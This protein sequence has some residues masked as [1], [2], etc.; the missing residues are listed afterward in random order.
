MQDRIVSPQH[1]IIIE[2]FT[3][4]LAEWFKTLNLEWLEKY[5]SVEPHDVEVLSN[6]EEHIIKPGG[7][8]FFART[9]NE[10]VGTCALIKHSDETYEL[11][12]MAVTESVQGKGIGKKLASAVIEYAKKNGGAFLFLE[13]NTKLVPAISLYRSLGFVEMPYPEPSV[14]KRSNIYMR[15]ELRRRA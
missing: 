5:F 11:A 12:K 9:D 7:E 15:L 2:R 1:T 3:L 8:I 14:Y 13:S 4:D 10:I 6:P